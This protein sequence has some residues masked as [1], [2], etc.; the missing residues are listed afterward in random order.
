M[1]EGEGDR[2]EREREVRGGE[3]RMTKMGEGGRR[4]GKVWEEVGCKVL[5]HECH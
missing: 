4:K 3:K 2:G 1:R 5:A